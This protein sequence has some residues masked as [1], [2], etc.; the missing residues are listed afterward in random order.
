MQYFVKMEFSPLM[1]EQIGPADA[2][3]F[4]A[5]G[6][7]GVEVSYVQPYLDTWQTFD[8]LERVQYLKEAGAEFTVHGPLVDVNLSSL[9]RTVRRT[10]LTQFKECLDFAQQLGGS[11]VV[12]HPVMSILGLPDGPWNQDDF[13]P[14]STRMQEMLM[15]GHDR[16]V[17]ALQELADY[18]PRLRIGVENLVYPHER[19]RSPSQ[20]AAL[21]DDVKRSNVGATLDIGHAWCSG[22][23]PAAFV[24]VLGSKLFHVHC[25]DNHGQR[26]EHLPIG[27][28]T[29]DMARVFQAL[30]IAEY[31]GILNFECHC[32][33]TDLAWVRS[34]FTDLETS[35]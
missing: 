29:I 12:V 16:C 17:L 13:Q 21:L 10:A 35:Q 15:A 5:S 14:A 33:E 28:G 11:L 18:A 30:A 2:E 3:R 1:A 23:D 34:H 19:Y 9:N 8:Y 22:H 20:L 26:D 25:H 6:F 4:L 31:K 27:E 24:E 7:H 32:P